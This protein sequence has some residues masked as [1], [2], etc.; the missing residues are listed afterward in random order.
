M[1]VLNKILSRADRA[2]A[3]LRSADPKGPQERVVPNSGS[4]SDPSDLD[5]FARN[6]REVEQNPDKVTQDAHLGVQKAEA[7]ALVWSKPAVYAT[8]AW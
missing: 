2:P 1:A 4:D 6:E 8:Y 3:E 5:L 7:A